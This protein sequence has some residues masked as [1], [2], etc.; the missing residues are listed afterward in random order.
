MIMASDRQ[1][2]DVQG[3]CGAPMV[4]VTEQSYA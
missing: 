4:E 3:V 1:R 2:S